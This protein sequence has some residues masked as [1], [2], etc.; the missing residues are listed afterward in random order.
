[1]VDKLALDWVKSELGKAIHPYN[2]DSPLTDKEA[3]NELERF[4]QDFDF[5]NSEKVLLH[6]SPSSDENEVRYTLFEKAALY[7]KNNGHNE[8]N[9]YAHSVFEDMVEESELLTKRDVNFIKAEITED[10]LNAI[11]NPSSTSKSLNSPEDIRKI[12]EFEK[13]VDESGK[14]IHITSD[15]HAEGVDSLSNQFDLEEYLVLS[16]DTSCEDFDTENYTEILGPLKPLASRLSGRGIS[17]RTW[18]E[19]KEGGRK[20]MDNYRGPRF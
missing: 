14:R 11:Y 20:L 19:G 1:M 9:L 12:R 7:L 18:A 10:E 15:Y 17:W 13:S 8:P 16:A 3:L 2:S 6:G 4:M 5:A